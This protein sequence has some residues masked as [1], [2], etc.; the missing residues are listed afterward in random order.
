M[1]K[2]LTYSEID[3]DIQTRLASASPSESV[4]L[5]AINEAINE[6]YAQYDIDYG[7]RSM[8]AYL[9]PNGYAIDITN[10]I[11]D[12]KHAKDLRY[13]SQSKHTEEFELVDDDDFSITVGDKRRVNEYSIS[14]RNGKTFIRLNSKS[15]PGSKILHN[16]NSLTDNGTWAMDAVNGDGSNLGTT[17]VKVLDQSKSLNFDADVSQSANNYILLENSTL[18]AIDLSEYNGLG[19]VQFNIY[20]P[21]ATNFSS[22]ELRWGSSSANYFSAS[23][24]TQADGS[25]FV[26]GWN[27]IEIDWSGAEETGIVTDT[28]IDY[29]AVKLSYTSSYTDETGFVIEQL[30]MYLPEAIELLYYTYNLS[31]D[32]SE[33]FQEEMTA[34]ATDTLLLPRR[35]KKLIVMGALRYLLPVVYGD[36]GIVRLRKVEKEYFMEVGNLGIDGG[37]KPKI[38]SKRLKIKKPW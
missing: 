32:A 11:S 38:G 24:T 15:N 16:M 10:F 9:V 18:T 2:F 1:G 35:Y 12:F 31:Q 23:V 5:S 27:R 6:L 28:A 4:R 14:E 25:A 21:D 13:L 36:D 33:N 19:K 30:R 26:N 29:L 17:V 7:I 34:T 8:V 3:S 20:I 37:N 22:V